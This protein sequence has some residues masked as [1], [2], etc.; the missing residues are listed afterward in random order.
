MFAIAR[1][2]G[3]FPRFPVDFC[4]SAS[5]IDT[6]DRRAI[7]TRLWRRV[8]AVARA[9]RVGCLNLKDLFAR[10]DAL[11][12][13]ESVSSTCR[14]YGEDGDGDRKCACWERHFEK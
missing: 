7:L 13:N 1:P 6:P 14:L 10:A 2:M 11:A 9:C 4:Q 5:K 3:R 8:L 12:K